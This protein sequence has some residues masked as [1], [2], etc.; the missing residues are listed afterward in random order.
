MYICIYLSIYIYIYIYQYRVYPNP[1]TPNP[2]PDDA[3]CPLRTQWAASIHATCPLYR[4]GGARR[5]AGAVAHI[6]CCISL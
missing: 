2:N 3:S 6:I 1:L 5:E 4:R